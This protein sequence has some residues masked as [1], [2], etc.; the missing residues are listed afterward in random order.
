MSKNKFEEQK[1]TA[2]R[3]AK[4]NI[5]DQRLKLD[6]IHCFGSLCSNGYRNSVVKIDFFKSESK[7]IMR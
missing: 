4:K 3:E 1:N 6:L 2:R 5:E 7:K